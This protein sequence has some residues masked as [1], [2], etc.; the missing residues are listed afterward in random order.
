MGKHQNIL[1]GAPL[2]FRPG[3]LSC[4]VH[5]FGGIQ[6]ETGFT[7]VKAR[8]R[9]AHSADQY[10]ALIWSLLSSIHKGH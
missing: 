1:E 5:R 9:R 3:N 8:T 2:F 6:S 10:A 7:L 4:C